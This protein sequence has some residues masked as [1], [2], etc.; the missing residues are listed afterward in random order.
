MSTAPQLLPGPDPLVG[1]VLDERYRVI[2]RLGEGGMGAVY[3]GEHLLIRKRVA[4]KVLHPQFAA[5]GDMIARF[6]Q[7]AVAATAIGHPNIVEVNDLGRT[8]DGGIYM[9]LELLVGED[10]A[11]TIERA[12]GLPIGRAVRIVQRVCDAVQAAHDKGI[13]HRDLKPEN[14]FLV[15]RDGQ[16]DFVKVLDFGISKIQGGE[17]SESGRAGTKTGSIVGTAYYMSPEQAQ[18]KKS[19]DHRTDVWAMGVILFRAL[20]GRYPF[21]DES[22]PMLIVKICS[23]SPRR[24]RDFRRDVPPELDAIVLRC[25]ER[26]PSVRVQ[27]CRELR[28]LLEPFTADRAHDSNALAA[29]MAGGNLA[30]PAPH[31]APVRIETPGARTGPIATDPISASTTHD[32]VAPAERA[33]SGIQPTTRS[34]SPWLAVMVVLVVLGAGGSWWMFGSHTEPP[35]PQTIVAPPPPASEPAPVTTVVAPPAV[36]TIAF[37]VSPSEAVV[38]ID[39]RRVAPAADGTIASPIVESDTALHELRVEARGFRTRVEDVRIAFEQRIVI[40][41]D[42]GNGVDDRREGHTPVEPRRRDHP[43]SAHTDHV[44]SGAPPPLLTTESP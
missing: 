26:D 9:V 38:L 12:G 40:A 27:S 44:P 14:I 34:R 18:G 42:P 41:L 39:G 4:I 29:T 24:V 17:L 10:F 7:E 22:Y 5:S 2:R 19:V 21:D 25:L 1:R 36:E 8:P 30:T 31:P 28:T 43:V 3:E 11:A 13:V 20:T 6:H 37:I 35:P 32:A 16:R 33:R 23:E 15:E